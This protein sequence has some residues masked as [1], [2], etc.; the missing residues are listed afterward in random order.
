MNSLILRDIQQTKEGAKSCFLFYTLAKRE[1][2]KELINGKGKDLV[3][4]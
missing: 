4:I 1:N 3:N 2:D